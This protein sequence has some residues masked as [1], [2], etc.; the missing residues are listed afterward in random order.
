MAESDWTILAGYWAYCIENYIPI[1]E[2]IEL[3]NTEADPEEIVIRKE[4]FENLSAEAKQVVFLIL[5]APQ[6]TFEALGTPITG[7]INP[8]SICKYLHKKVR[9]SLPRVR[10]VVKEL[11][12]YANNL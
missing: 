9:W 10:R 5:N 1:D 8:A 6:E 11:T 2:A 12:A 4:L 3:P 7:K